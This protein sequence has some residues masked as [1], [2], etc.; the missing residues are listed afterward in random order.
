MSINIGIIDQ[1]VRQLAGD[2]A[3]EFDTRL[4]IRNDEFKRKAIREVVNTV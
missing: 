3:G 1:R 2:L 4:N